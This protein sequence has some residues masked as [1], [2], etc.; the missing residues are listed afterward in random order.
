[1]NRVTLVLSWLVIGA[2]ALSARQDLRAQQPAGQGG[3]Q[4]AGQTTGAPTFSYHTIML[5][6]DGMP[7]WR[8]FAPGGQRD[9]PLYD[10]VTWGGMTPMPSPDELVWTVYE[11]RIPGLDYDQVNYAH[12]NANL[13]SAYANDGYVVSLPP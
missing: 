3:A 2:L 6:S 12:I 1:M 5:A 8:L 4:P 9:V 13:W 10:L 11:I 7:L